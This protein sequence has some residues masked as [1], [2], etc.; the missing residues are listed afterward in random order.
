MYAH[1][2]SEFKIAGIILKN[3]LT[4][5]PMYLGYAGEGGTVSSV[6]LDHYRLM[7]KSGVA[8]VVVENATID[9][10]TGSGSNRTLRVDSD[11]YA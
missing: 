8:M 9:H 2:F 11:D 3:R 7:A 10:P 5:A 4:M 1:L 6:L